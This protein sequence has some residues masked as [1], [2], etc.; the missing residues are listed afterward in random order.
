MLNCHY[1]VHMPPV[2]IIQY[3]Y[4]GQRFGA[5]ASNVGLWLCIALLFICDCNPQT[6]VICALLLWH[7]CG[8]LFHFS[9]CFMK[10]CQGINIRR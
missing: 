4:P 10:D 1:T 6:S 9:L 8:Q 7:M 5:N 3:I 2:L